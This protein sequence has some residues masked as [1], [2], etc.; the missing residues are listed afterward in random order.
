MRKEIV[1]LA[2]SH[3]N[4]GICL[5]GKTPDTKMWIRPVTA[6]GQIPEELVVNLK[7]GDVID[8]D[9]G[10]FVPKCHQS[11]NYLYN[12][13]PWVKKH[14][15][16]KRELALFVDNPA[17]LWEVRDVGGNNREGT[18]SIHADTVAAEKMDKSLYFL[19]LPEMSLDTEHDG[20][21]QKYYG[22]FDYYGRSYRLPITDR[23]FGDVCA[24]SSG[25]TELQNPLIC[26][27]LSEVFNKT[28]AC[29]KLIA[30]VIV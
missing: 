12:P 8:L 18:T 11:E 23:D 14:S 7:I 22:I 21:K 4:L 24:K 30:G 28:G 9:L 10:N 25:L 19:S 29:Y 2:L 1:I 15:L 27:S 3:R 26:V 16:S 6:E 13:N 20:K 5:A 17:D